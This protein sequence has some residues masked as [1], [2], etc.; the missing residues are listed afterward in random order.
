M[1]IRKL[2]KELGS[3]SD[4][5]L[6]LLR[7]LGQTR[8]DDPEQ[9]LPDGVEA[10]VRRHAKDLVAAPAPPPPARTRRP[11]SG[12]PAEWLSEAGLEPRVDPMEERAA[13]DKAMAGVRKM[14]APGGKRTAAKPPAPKVGPLVPPARPLATPGPVPKLA[15]SPRAAAPPAPL[16]PPR[17]PVAEWRGR[18]EAAEAELALLRGRVEADEVEKA[19]LRERVDAAERDFADADAHRRSIQRQLSEREGGAP[20]P[21]RDVFAR[22]GLL[23]DDEASLALRALLDAH[24]ERELLGEIQV[25]GADALEAYLWDR[26]LLLA[27]GEDAPPGVAVVRVPVERSEGHQSGPNR[28]AMARFSTACLVT[29]KRRIVIVGGSPAYH[30]V[31]REGIDPRIDLRLVAGNRRG[32]IPET[33]GADHVFVWASTI[34]DHR[35][36]ERFPEAVV[37]PH[38]GIARMLA[39]ATAYVEGK[40]A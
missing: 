38:R 12:I 37:L 17:D 35:V 36:S 28:A 14:G 29:N 32:R 31:L 22:R 34:L 20:V 10:V 6:G 3:T 8:Y 24:R 15:S 16:P 40:P 19:V 23:G 18:A 13:F 5:V 26:V 7:R 1:R 25:A 27:E 9:Q 39:A 4:A 2:A 21:L 33:Q 11:D 30:R